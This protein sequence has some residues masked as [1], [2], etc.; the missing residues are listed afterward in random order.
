MYEPKADIYA[1]LSELNYSLMMANDAEFSSLPLIT[2][3]VASNIPQYTLDMDIAVQN[4]DVAIDLWAEVSTELTQMLS[5]V[6]SKMRS[7]FYTMTFAGEVPNIDK[8]V[9]HYST[10][11]S[12]RL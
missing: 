11:F 10:R 4:I 6:E 8:S 3:N 2:Y 5:E 7:I 1:A 9:L 12:K